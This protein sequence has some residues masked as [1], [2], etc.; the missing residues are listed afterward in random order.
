M[1]RVM[2]GHPVWHQTKK[3][4][5]PRKNHGVLDRPERVL[6]ERKVRMPLMLV[7]MLLTVP[8]KVAVHASDLL[9]VVEKPLELPELLAACLLLLRNPSSVRLHRY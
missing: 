4:K 6:L 2:T 5:R 8:L 7:G 9:N 3:T 1:W